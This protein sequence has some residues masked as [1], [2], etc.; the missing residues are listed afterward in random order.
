MAKSSSL[1]QSSD[2]KTISFKRKLNNSE[3]ISPPAKV[4]KTSLG[5]HHVSNNLGDNQD[6]V[7]H[8]IELKKIKILSFFESILHVDLSDLVLT[9][10]T[11]KEEHGKLTVVGR[12]KVDG[13]ATKQMRHVIPYSFVEHLIQ[14]EINISTCPQE[15]LKLLSKTILVFAKAQK[16]YA[17]SAN[18]LETKPYNDILELPKIANRSISNNGN[19]VFLA[20]PIKGGALK[21]TPV[22]RAKAETDFSIFNIKFIQQALD[23]FNHALESSDEYILN[24]ASEALSR[25]IFIIFNKSKY[26]VFA[27]EG[28]TVSY[29]LRLYKSE[30]SAFKAGKDYEVMTAREL[31]SMNHDTINKC[32][33]IVDCEGS[34]IRDIPKALKIINDIIF[35]YNMLLECDSASIATYNSKYNYQLKLSN[36][37]ITIPEYNQ[38]LMEAT[39]LMSFLS[40]SGPPHRQP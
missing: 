30:D 32:I 12:P 34:K 21:W 8:K 35:K 13:S 14:S 10:I 2:Q 31:Q 17:V 26:A 25:F 4:R 16:G 39:Y 33:R 20:S 28:N 23:K 29:E 11:F 7:I 27:K 3:D 9:D 6:F 22:K 37:D 5:K 18:D 38:E 15:A 36:A 1:Q 19:T 40:Y 24:I